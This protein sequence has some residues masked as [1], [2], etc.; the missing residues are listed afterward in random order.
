MWTPNPKTKQI[1]SSAWNHFE[2]VSYKVSSRW[3]F[4]RLLQDG[5]YS[6]KSDYK[7]KWSKII[8]AAR[9]NFYEN[10]QPDTLADETR[11]RILRHG[12]FLSFEEW[13][14]AFS[15]T[16]SCDLDKLVDQDYYVECWFEARAMADQFRTIID[17]PLTLVPFGGQPSIPFKW[18]IAKSLEDAFER[19]QKPIIILYF[20]DRDTAGEQIRQT[21]ENDIR[22]WCSVDFELR[23]CGLTPEQ[24]ISSDVP[25]NPEKP[26]EYQWEALTD[27]QARKIIEESLG[28][29]INNEAYKERLK[30]IAEYD[31]LIQKAISEIEP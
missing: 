15:Y 28:G 10:W 5:Y 21:A 24:A 9:H 26:G 3:L 8:S 12:S 18:E 19:Y 17:F 11:E 20:G 30:R 7:S 16:A 6:K 29:L 25:E 4:Y 22:K 27:N 14:E 2:S 1:L 13:Q 31:T 23:Y